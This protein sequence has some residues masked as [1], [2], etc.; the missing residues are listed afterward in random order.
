MGIAA[1][2]SIDR[3]LLCL[4]RVPLFEI[5]NSDCTCEGPRR[6]PDSSSTAFQR[7]DGIKVD[8]ILKV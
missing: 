1:A 3:E 4:F 8:M 5:G 2:G 7:T 6:L